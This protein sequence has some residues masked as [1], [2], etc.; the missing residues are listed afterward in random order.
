MPKMQNSKNYIKNMK[1]VELTKEESDCYMKIVQFG[2]MDDM[3]DFA[4]VIGR[5]RLAIEYLRKLKDLLP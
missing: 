5:E 3:F 1:K 2:N 4:Y